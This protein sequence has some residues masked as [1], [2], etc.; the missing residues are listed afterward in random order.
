MV[1]EARK[2]ANAKWDKE[3]MTILGCRVKKDYAARFRAACVA[4]GTTPNAVLKQAA[5][6]LW[7]L[8]SA[9]YFLDFGSF[10]L[11]SRQANNRM[12]PRISVSAD[13]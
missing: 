7:L 10:R 2:R 11:F 12:I 3:N 13:M 4:A 6:D 9:V 1:T 5:D 8:L